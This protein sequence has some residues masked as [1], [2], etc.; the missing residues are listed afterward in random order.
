MSMKFKLAYGSKGNIESA[1]EA[2]TIDGGDLVVTTGREMA[3]ID[4]SNGI[5]YIK[6][7]LELF[8]TEDDLA[9]YLETEAV[10]TGEIVGVMTDDGSYEY[11]VIGATTEEDEEGNTTTTYTADSALSTSSDDTVIEF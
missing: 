2:G 3:F 4:S 5:N 8:D 11:R 6:A 7:R 1:I 10:Y 9:T